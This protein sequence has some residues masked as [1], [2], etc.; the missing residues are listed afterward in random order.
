MSTL[1]LISMVVVVACC[2]YLVFAERYNDGLFGRLGLSGMAFISGL[3]LIERIAGQ[4]HYLSP[5]TVCFQAAVALFF[6]RHTY[7]YVLWAHF[8]RGAWKEAS[9]H[10]ADDRT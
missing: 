2:T 3:L 9:R 8:G 1:S 5:L 6:A 10:A 4:A 7:N